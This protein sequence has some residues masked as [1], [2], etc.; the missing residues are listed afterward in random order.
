MN[1]DEDGQSVSDDPREF[2]CGWGAAFVNICVT[3]PVNKVMYR[4][5]V[6]GVRVIP[7]MTQLKTEGF[8][9]LYKGLLPPLMSKTTSVSLMF[10]T[11]AKY[12]AVLDTNFN[13][14]I[15]SPILRLSL[16]AFMS[17]STEALLCPFERIQMLLQSRDLGNSFQNTFHAFKR[18]KV[19]GF[20]EYYRGLIP[21]LWRNGPSNV[22]FFGCRD[23]LNHHVLK[24]SKLW[25]VKLTQDFITGESFLIYVLMIP[26]IHLNM[27]TGAVLGAFISTIFYPLNVMRTKMQ[28]VAPG[29]PNLSMRRALILVYIER[30][31]SI[32]K[33]FYGVN[34]NA[35]RALMSWGII[36]TSYEMFRKFLYTSEELESSKSLSSLNQH[37]DHHYDHQS[38]HNDSNNNNNIKHLHHRNNHL[39]NLN[40]VIASATSVSAASTNCDPKSSYD[41]NS[42]QNDGNRIK[43]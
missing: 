28:T 20:K 4:Q 38:I 7:A 3:F 22:L 32:R 9:N 19:Y 25:W 13:H 36:N 8:I 6:H 26:L 41:D 2:I 11:Y 34:T 1:Q 40:P 35:T 15:P 18:L 5:M 10:G 27:T 12:K 30:N 23:H 16:A 43:K 29:S 39:R 14:V 24:P 37:H 17:G 33:I 42:D 21:I 31:R